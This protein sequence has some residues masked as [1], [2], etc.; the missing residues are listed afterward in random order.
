[1]NTGWEF[2]YGEFTPFPNQIGKFAKITLVFEGLGTTTVDWKEIGLFNSPKVGC[3]CEDGFYM[4]L[5]TPG[6]RVCT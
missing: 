3:D 5:D 1:M 4:N 6:C 2:A